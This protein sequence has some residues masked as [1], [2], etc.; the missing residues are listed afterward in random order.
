MSVV[1][2]ATVIHGSS[3]RRTRQNTMTAK[4]ASQ[5]TRETHPKASAIHK[6]IQHCSSHFSKV[7]MEL[8]FHGTHE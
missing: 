1:K 4:I 7:S 2:S 8:A 5:R 3:K 6:G